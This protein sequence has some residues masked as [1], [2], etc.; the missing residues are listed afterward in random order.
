MSAQMWCGEAA[1]A[2][3]CVQ[4]INPQWFILTGW[5]WRDRFTVCEAECVE[6][7]PHSVHS[8]CGNNNSP[9]YCCCPIRVR[10][11]GQAGHWANQALA[12]WFTN[13]LMLLLLV[14]GCV[15]RLIYLTNQHN[16]NTWYDKHIQLIDWKKK[17]P[18]EWIY[19]P[20]LK[21]NS[22]FCSSV[23]CSCTC[24]PHSKGGH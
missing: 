14:L 16:Y 20:S 19:F 18:L 1:Q 5:Q 13:L 10:H 17:L 12:R 2:A 11:D 4:Q 3:W 7:S 21:S 24:D 15:R 8:C 23:M 22:I 9:P 6:T